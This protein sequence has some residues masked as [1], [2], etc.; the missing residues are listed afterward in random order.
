MSEDGDQEQGEQKHVQI[1]KGP[2]LRE[3]P[4]MLNVFG[5]A[6]FVR[7][8]SITTVPVQMTGVVFRVFGTSALSSRKSPIFS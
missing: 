6:V 2:P 1:Q 4:N 7:T 5:L 3:G 8:G